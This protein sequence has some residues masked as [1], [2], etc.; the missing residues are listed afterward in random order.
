M[1]HIHWHGWL[2]LGWSHVHGLLVHWHGWFNHLITFMDGSLA[3]MFMVVAMAGLFT[4][5]HALAG[6]WLA[7]PLTLSCISNF[8][9]HVTTLARWY[10]LACMW[11]AGLV[12]WFVHWL[13]TT[14]AQWLIWLAFS[15]AHMF[16]AGWLAWLAR[17][18]AWHYTDLLAGSSLACLFTA[19]LFTG[20]VL[21]D[22]FP[23]AVY[24]G[25]S[26]WLALV[27]GL[28]VHSELITGIAGFIGMAWLFMAAFF[29]WYGATLARW[30]GSFSLAVYT[31][32]AGSLIGRLLFMACL[33]M[34]G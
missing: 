33:F 22:S 31:G 16:M 2:V 11:L 30:H 24:A 34:A 25:S 27:H 12:G 10:L 3:R 17:S 32:T 15:L 8:H 20:I 28:L 14:L 19:G 5:L 9:W 13:D 6:G 23:L 21:H 26:H 18:L 1:V 4:D 29:H 7:R